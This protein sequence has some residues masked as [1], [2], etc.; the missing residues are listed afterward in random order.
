MI[1]SKLLQ[2]LFGAPDDVAD[3]YVQQLKEIMEL[4]SL[5]NKT[6]KQQELIT[7]AKEYIESIKLYEKAFEAVHIARIN[8]FIQSTANNLK[9]FYE[10]SEHNLI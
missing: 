2:K 4:D 3:F 5:A 8:L 6:K 10:Q 1:T 7:A 9:S